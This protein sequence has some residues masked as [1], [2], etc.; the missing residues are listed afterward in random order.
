MTSMIDV[1]FLLLIFFLVNVGYHRA[2]RELDSGIQ[3]E[4]S[5]KSRSPL[6]PVIVEIV[7]EGAGEFRM[8]LGS[9]QFDDP[10]ELTRVLSQM[11]GAGGAFVKAGDDAPFALAAA[12]IQAC[13]DSGY[14][15]VSYIPAAPGR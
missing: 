2:E 4:A 12:A 3:T 15:N 11:R 1:V 6:E 10:A 14:L 7:R 9:R 5:G 13:Y 8:Q